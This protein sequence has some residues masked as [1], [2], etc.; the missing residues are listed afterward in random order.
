M[1][2][3]ELPYG[4]AQC[5]LRQGEILATDGHDEP[6]A[7]SFDEGRAILAELGVAADSPAKD[8]ALSA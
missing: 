1:R 5:L 8:E 4:L 6:A 7:E 2:E 3:L